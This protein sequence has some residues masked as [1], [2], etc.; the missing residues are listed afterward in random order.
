MTQYKPVLVLNRLR[1]SKDNRAVFDERFHRG[2]NILRGENGSGKTTIA[3]FIFFALG[4]EGLAWKTEALLCDAVFADVSINGTSVTLRRDVSAV[5]QRPMSIYWG[6]MEAAIEAPAHKWETYPYAARGERESFS[7]VLFRALG[8]P[9]E[10]GE[11]TSRITMHQILRLMYVDQRTSFD[12]IFRFEDFDS[13]LVR[14]AVGALLCGYFDPDLY[15]RK[16]QL[17]EAEGELS[18]ISKE[19]RTIFD[20]LGPT[21]QGMTVGFLEQELHNRR[22]EREQV[23]SRLDEIQQSLVV[24]PEL[25]A[26]LEKQRESLRQELISAREESRGVRER[27]EQLEFEVADSADFLTAVKRR[28]DAIREAGDVHTVLGYVQ[29]DYCPACYHHLVPGD[30]GSCH[31]CRSPL[32]GKSGTRHLLRMQNE[33]AIQLTESEALQKQRFAD[34]ERLRQELPLL[35]ARENSLQRRYEEIVTG[36]ASRFE[37]TAAELNQRL[38]YLDREQEDVERRLVLARRIEALSDRKAELSGIISKLRDEIRARQD[39]E[40][41]R[42]IDAKVTVSDIAKGLL[43]RDLLRE[44]GFANAQAVQFDFGENRI[45]VDG[46]TNFAASSMVFLKNSFHLALLS[47]STQRDYFRYPRFLILDNI[48]DGGMEEERSHR[49]QHLVVDASGATKVEHQI[50]MT[51]AKIAPDLEG[52]KYTVGRRFT[53]DAKSLAIK[54]R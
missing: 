39:L 52:S 23:S 41:T 37:A 40:K 53:P 6:P 44:E 12:R 43:N 54:A 8:I 10:Q 7:T 29:F 42:K 18:F 1:V 4:G 20:V 36:P 45:T 33:L 21:S 24:S 9:E 22:V 3:D 49:F 35:R 2:V 31:V 25:E 13:A 11:L 15:D 34:L 5:G 38:G 48:E 19:L 17:Q 26:E 14:E 16:V 27:L 50:I 46:R 47:A 32:D 28:L 30:E 51:T